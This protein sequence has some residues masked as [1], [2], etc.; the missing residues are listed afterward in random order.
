MATSA[1]VGIV[2]IATRPLRSAATSFGPDERVSRAY[3]TLAG[4]P[5]GICLDRMKSSRIAINA[6]GDGAFAKSVA[7]DSQDVSSIS[8]R[9]STSLTPL[10]CM[11]LGFGR[12][13]DGRKRHKT[14][15]SWI[16]RSSDHHAD[17]LTIA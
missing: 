14:Y 16:V 3:T 5:S 13:G 9:G 10:S 15:F 17:G 7:C 2:P 12:C 11:G 8:P 1:S 6:S 4:V